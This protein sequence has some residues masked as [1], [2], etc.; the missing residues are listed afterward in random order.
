MLADAGDAELAWVGRAQTADRF[1]AFGGDGDVRRI[2]EPE[3]DAG[4][5]HAAAAVAEA[6]LEQF[7]QA[8]GKPVVGGMAVADLHDLHGGGRRPPVQ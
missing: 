2:I 6:G 3:R 1:P 4:R 8:A 7:A 5:Q